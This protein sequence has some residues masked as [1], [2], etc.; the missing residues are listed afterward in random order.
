MGKEDVVLGF[1]RVIDTDARVEHI[2]AAMKLSRGVD[3]TWDKYKA[4]KPEPLTQ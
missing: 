2:I 1:R 4:G 3:V